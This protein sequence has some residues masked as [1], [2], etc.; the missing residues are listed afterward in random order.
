M[1]ILC[2]AHEASKSE[3]LGTEKIKSTREITELNHKRRRLPRRG[4]D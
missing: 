2:L 4:L 3:I 1:I